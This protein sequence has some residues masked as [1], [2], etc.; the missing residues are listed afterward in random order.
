MRIARGTE[1]QMAD[2]AIHR[3]LLLEM[4]A[5]IAPCRRA[6]RLGE[7]TGHEHPDLFGV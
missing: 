1:T 6:R 7:V 5:M 4:S 3:W 2:A